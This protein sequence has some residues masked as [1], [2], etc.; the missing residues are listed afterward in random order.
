MVVR[1]TLERESHKANIGRTEQ[2]EKSLTVVKT[3]TESINALQ[4]TA[5]RRVEAR[6]ESV[7]RKTGK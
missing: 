1:N 7:V 4:N 5:E 6:E 3:A 2:L